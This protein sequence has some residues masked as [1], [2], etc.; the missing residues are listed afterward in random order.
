M[1]FFTQYSTYIFVLIGLIAGIPAV[2]IFRQRANVK[3]VLGVAG[4]CLLYSLGSLVSALVFAK[5]EGLIGG[6]A[7]GEGAV[8]TYGIYLIGPFLLMLAAKLTRL[9]V[10]GVMDV[11]ALYAMPSL[12]LMRCNCLFSGCCYGLPI[13]TTGLT[14]PTRESEMVFYAVM[15]VVFW[16]ML[17]K[18]EIPGQLFPLMMVSYGAFRFVNQ[19]FRDDGAAGMNI[20]HIW[21]LV[22]ILIGLS[23]FLNFRAKAAEAAKKEARKA[24]RKAKSKK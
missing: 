6:D 5:L 13:G 14:W 24:S 21:S 20:S 15:F 22:A 12:F 17:K 7:V 3:S 1:D 9:N 8:S 16:I 11:F 19:W 4:L 23:L 18:N 10:A 2:W